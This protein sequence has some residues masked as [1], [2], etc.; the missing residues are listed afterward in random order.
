MP[1]ITGLDNYLHYLTTSAKQKWPISQREENVDT[2]LYIWGAVASLVIL[3]VPPLNKIEF[4]WA[5]VIVITFQSQVAFHYF[6]AV[7]QKADKL[8]LSYTTFVVSSPV[9][10][11]KCKCPSSSSYFKIQKVKNYLSKL[12]RAEL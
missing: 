1:E 11:L 2:I 12:K 3:K 5:A 7:L 10:L 9:A 8:E 4:H 6:F